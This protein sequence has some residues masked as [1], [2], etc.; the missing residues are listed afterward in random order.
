MRE[1]KCGASNSA[2]TVRSRA[3]DSRT[4]GYVLSR[5]GEL[6]LLVGATRFQARAY[7]RAAD[8]VR[9][10]ASGDLAPAL[11]N[12]SLIRVRHLGPS[13]V[14]VLE[15][16]IERGQSSMLER[17]RS[18]IPEG[19]IEVSRVPSVRRGDVKR[20]Y[21]VLGVDSIDSL[22]AAALDGRLAGLPRYGPKTVARVL[23]GVA[24]V[25]RALSARRY[26]DAAREADLV[27]RTVT[28]DP[29]VS[30][31]IVAGDLRRSCDVVD[32]IVVVAACSARPDR[33]AADLASAPS[34]VQCERTG[35]GEIALRYVDG[36]PVR[37][38][39]VRP[40]RFGTALWRATGSLAHT[41][42]LPNPRTAADEH[43]VYDQFGLPFI[44]PELRE[45]LGEIEAARAGRLPV[46]VT[47][48]DVRG[49]LHVHSEWSD[50]S[51][52]IAELAT[53]A[54]ANGWS[55]IGISDHSQSAFYAGGLSREEVVAQHVEID[56]LNATLPQAFRVLKGIEVNVLAD[57]TLDYD[58]T[59][60]A[61]F[62]FVIASIHS[63]FAMDRSTMT[64]RVLKALDNPYVTVL[65]HPTGRLLLAREPYALDVDAVITR[66]AARGVAV[67]L[68]A[69]PARLD[70]SW[71]W[72]HVAKEHGCIVAIGADAHS[73]A[74]LG[75]MA[76]GIRMARKAWLERA[77]ILNS[78]RV[79]DLARQR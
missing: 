19:L 74:G 9:G 15:E 36:L 14:N 72:C 29:R 34:V 73:I 71:R 32:A 78:R 68:N 63:R 61:D 7:K 13:T 53:A 23:K 21:E 76:L 51:A 35:P 37:V 52:S 28:R 57:G 41:D 50:G 2:N 25:K 22:E 55:Y 20:L 27:R 18:E 66:A 11:R 16:L 3:L 26:N 8:A 54:Q 60:L 30:H 65:G 38:V 39:C 49:V 44:E 40:D 56:Q 70:L 10:L 47:D 24:L 12:G 31:A 45:G 17:L 58:D 75:T 33:V 4:A 69:D 67:E 64:S 46:L 79:C 6:L 5:I 59:L 77:D 43:D 42:R 62:D 48:N 1:G